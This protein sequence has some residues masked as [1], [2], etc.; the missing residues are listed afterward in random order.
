MVAH[1]ARHPGRL[2]LPVAALTL[3]ARNRLQREPTRAHLCAYFAWEA[4]VRLAVAAEPPTDV[5]S[6]ALPSVGDLVHALASSSSTSTSRPLLDVV[7]LLA[8]SGAPKSTTRSKLLEFLPRYR[9]E[10][11]HGGISRVDAD[12]R[13]ARVL[14]AGI[15]A[16]WEEGL[17]WP[18]SSA[19]VFV[20]AVE[21][22]SFGKRRAHVYALEGLAS[23]AEVPDESLHSVEAQVLPGR[24]YLRAQARYRSL[25]PWVVYDDGRVLFFNGM[26]GRGAKYLDYAKNDHVPSRS[27]VGKLPQLEQE[28]ANLFGRTS[29]DALAPPPE[30][31]RAAERPPASTRRRWIALGAA[32]V[33]AVGG[34]AALVARPAAQTRDALQSTPASASAAIANEPSGAEDV[35]V[36][37]TKPAVQAEFRRAIDAYLAADIESAEHAF[38]QVAADEPSHPWPHLG[39]AIAYAIEQRFD[40]A[41]AESTQAQDLARGGRCDVRDQKLFAA[42]EGSDS[43]TFAATCINYRAQYPRYALGLNVL[44]F[45]GMDRGSRD[46]RLGR[47]EAALAADD[48]H[49]ITYLTKSWTLARLDD[50]DGA[51]A[52][53][54]GGLARQATAPWLLDQRGVLRL[55]QADVQGAKEDFLL[56]MNHH[57]PSQA[58]VHYA[59]ALLRSGTADDEAMLKRQRDSM[60]AVTDAD[61]RANEACQIAIAL[62]ARGR[63]READGLLHGVLDP[64]PGQ[65]PPKAGTAARCL[66]LNIWMDDAIDR[67]GEKEARW[68]LDALRDLFHRPQLSKDD[69]AKFQWQDAALHGIAAAMT[70]RTAAAEQELRALREERS[71]VHLHEVLTAELSARIQL[72][73]KQPVAVREPEAS[74]SPLLRARAA[75]LKGRV[76]ERDKDDDAAAKAYEALLELVSECADGDAALVLAGA[77]YVADGLAHLAAIQARRGQGEGL[78]RALAAFDR[79]WPKPDPDLAPVKL[80]A[81]SRRARP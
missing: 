70:G 61:Q 71:D 6:L 14:L 38:R 44:A 27:L 81:A 28:L 66:L 54:A 72:V 59:M 57:G 5:G 80:V 17:F 10:H 20:D 50:R 1:D 41:F 62:Y 64:R 47:V 9:N 45:Y 15:D 40:E 30:T 2:P 4:S 19:L 53:L 74:A 79:I 60:L 24:V 22:D 33:L 23:Q 75:H 42:V 25:H 13:A 49:P 26:K 43:P 56:A 58:T 3:E 69:I 31:V 63:V 67:L 55:A 35:P 52:A 8:G 18:T 21:I 11:F 65:E 34:G 32:A 46:E 16:A 7:T 29:G 76:A 68:R 51:K 48:D 37:S 39:L 78:T 73:T 36:A 77:P 12:A